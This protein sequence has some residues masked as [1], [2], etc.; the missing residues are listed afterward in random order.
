MMDVQRSDRAVPDEALSCE[1]AELIGLRAENSDLREA[2]QQYADKRN[3]NIDGRPHSTRWMQ[4]E[5]G[6]A[7]A[8]AVLDMP[9]D[10]G[11]E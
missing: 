10:E 6:Y 9:I 4:H 8:R 5:H 7:I 1:C 2:L 3:W 11:E